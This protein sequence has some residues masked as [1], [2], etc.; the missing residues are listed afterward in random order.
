MHGLN[1]ILL[2]IVHELCL[3]WNE[4]Y[5]TYVAKCNGLTKCAVNIVHEFVFS[6]KWIRPKHNELRYLLGVINFNVE[7]L[8]LLIIVHELCLRWNKFYWTYVAKCNGLTKY[9]VN[10]VHEFVFSVKWIRPKQNELRYLLG[11][12]N[13][14]VEYL[15]LLI[16]VH[17]LC[18]RWNEFYW[19]YVA[20]C[21]G[22]TKYMVNIVHEFVFSVK[23]IR[24]KQ[25]ELRYLLGVINFNVEY[26][27]LLIIVHELCLRWNEFYWTYAAKCNGLTK[28]MVNIVHEF[29]FSVKWIR[30]KQNELRYLLGVINFNVE[31]LILLII[32][33]ELCLRWNEFYW[34]YVAKCNGLTKYMV[35]IVH[36]FVFSVKWIR[37]K[38]IELR[39]LLGVIN[40][41]VE[42]VS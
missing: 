13:F 20:K 16:I 5:W 39:Y 2:I 11:V 9:M 23:W 21:N 4:F 6:V 34:T 28:Y 7:Y 8:I 33:H 35:N 24:P 36:E 38:H 1:L 42:I 12:I 17:E 3:R 26:L 10:I 27:I 15:I 19:T 37:P 40:F 30:P 14:N 41:L 31:Y 22:L 25:N 18:L 32:V 29:V